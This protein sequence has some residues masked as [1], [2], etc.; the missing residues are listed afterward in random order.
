MPAPPP[1][2]P[3]VLLV[4]DHADT[5]S[6]MARLLR[7]AGFDVLKADSFTAAVAAH[8]GRPIDL[9]VSD[10]TLPDGSGHDVMRELHRRMPT[11]KGIAVSGHGADADRAASLAAG[12]DRHVTKPIDFAKFVQTCRDVLAG[13]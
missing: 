7:G 3:L 13:G 2:T 12:F 4:D 6:L 9:L 8:D 1:N 5:V 10:L 11:L